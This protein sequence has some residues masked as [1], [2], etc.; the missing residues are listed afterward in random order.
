M[1]HNKIKK[2]EN[3]HRDYQISGNEYDFVLKLF[4]IFLKQDD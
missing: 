4:Y 1:L 3:E 2:R